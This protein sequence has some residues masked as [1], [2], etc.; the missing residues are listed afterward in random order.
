MGQYENWIGQEGRVSPHKI[1]L[2]APF[3]TV[4]EFHLYRYEDDSGIRNEGQE[5]QAHRV[6]SNSLLQEP[7]LGALAQFLITRSSNRRGCTF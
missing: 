2:K 3:F 4:R 7:V 5:R 6:A 1:S